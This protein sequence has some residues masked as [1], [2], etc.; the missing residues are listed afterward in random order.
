MRAWLVLAAVAALAACSPPARTF[1][2]ASEQEFMQAC[3]QGS[4]APG[5]CACTWEK[6]T[7]EVD[8]NDFAA[9]ERLPGP[10]RDAHPIMTQILGM[11]QACL[12]SLTAPPAGAEPAPAEPR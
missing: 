7:A 11:R 10:Q 6:I 2:P 8:P 3:E 4:P 9:L 1:A 5:L 12:A